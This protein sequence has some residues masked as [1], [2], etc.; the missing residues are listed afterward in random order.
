MIF[1]TNF[2]LRITNF[3]NKLLPHNQFFDYFFSFF[4]LRGNSIFIWIV[5]IILILVLEENKYPGIQKRDV[6]FLLTFFL[7]FLITAFL[8]NIILKNT[9]HRPRPDRP[10]N[11]DTTASVVGSLAGCPKDYSFPSGHASTAFAAATVIGFFDKK[12]KWLYYLIAVI[13]SLSRIYLECHYFLDIFIGGII[14]WII[15]TIILTLANSKK[16]ETNN[17]QITYS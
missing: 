10:T 12:G 1:L 3:I 5:I 9:F 13:I 14:G 2:D 6:K 7:S 15:S 17:N 4:S 11:L 16:Q 8:V